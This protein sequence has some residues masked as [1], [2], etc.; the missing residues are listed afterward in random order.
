MQVMNL[1]PLGT[2]YLPPCVEILEPVPTDGVL[3]ESDIN[4]N[5]DLDDMGENDYTWEL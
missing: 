2:A 5:T 1:K 4:R 3:V